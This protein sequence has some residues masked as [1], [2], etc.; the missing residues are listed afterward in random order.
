MR[1]KE[2][3]EEEEKERDREIE[4]EGVRETIR[5]EKIWTGRERRT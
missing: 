3:E 1:K 2:E 5:L 4:R